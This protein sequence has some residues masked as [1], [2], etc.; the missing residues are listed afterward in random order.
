MS[1]KYVVSQL[2]KELARLDRSGGMQVD[3]Q[4]I[5]LSENFVSVTILHLE[6]LEVKCAGLQ[7]Q[8]DDLKLRNQLLRDRPDLPIERLVAY[9]K[10]VRERDELLAHCE[11][12]DKD[13]DLA[14]EIL[15]KIYDSGVKLDQLHDAEAHELL[16]NHKFAKSPKQSLLL[17]D[18]KVISSL[19]FPTA[20]RKMWNGAEVNEWLIDKSNQLIEQEKEGVK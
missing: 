5:T 2:K 6:E 12:K 4:R 3:N 17:R 1:I 8:N 13:I 16:V 7:H 18:A 20:I 15:S 11:A 10:I 9:D 14:L 19:R